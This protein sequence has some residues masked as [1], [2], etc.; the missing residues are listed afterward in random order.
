MD[1]A[2]N[3][4]PPRTKSITVSKH[5]YSQI[6]FAVLVISPHHKQVL[7]YLLLV[8]VTYAFIFPVYFMI[9][10]SF[11]L[12]DPTVT[13]SLFP[14][15]FLGWWK[16]FL[17]TGS[18]FSTNT[19]PKS[20]QNSVITSVASVVVTLL[21]SFPAGYVF[22]RFNFTA[23][24][25]LFFFLFITR[26]A[27]VVTMIIPYLIIFAALG[28]VDTI[29]GLVIAYL[30]FNVPIAVILFA[31]FMSA[32]PKEFDEASFIDGYSL[33]RYFLKIFIPLCK[34]AI[35]VVALFVWWQTWSEMFFASILSRVDAM[36]LVANMIVIFGRTGYGVPPGIISTA[37]VITMIPAFILLFLAR[38][39]LAKGFT[40]GR[41]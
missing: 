35:A 25:H 22:S 17:T 27:P 7:R 8:I 21:I 5:K 4:F 2:L 18:D 33:S 29:A 38:N 10:A 1:G 13:G 23:D 20:I 3:R 37:G 19:W 9:N 12:K 41:M 40:F 14:D 24:K 26:V 34:P 11:S 15:G 31:S 6:A 39:Y 28:L 30:S 32:I 16:F 36:P